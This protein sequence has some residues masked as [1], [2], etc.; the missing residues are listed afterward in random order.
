MRLPGRIYK[1][2]YLL[3]IVIVYAIP[4]IC[5]FYYINN[6]AVNVPFWDQW[7]STVRWVI[8]YYEGNF[9][10]GELTE[11]QNDS[12]PFVTNALTIVISLMTRLNMKVVFFTGYIFYIISLVVIIHFVKKDTSLDRITLTL[13]VPLFYYAFN[14]YYLVA[15]SQNQGCLEYSIL[16]LAALITTY[17]LYISKN[18]YTYFFSSMVM[19][20]VCTFTFAAGLSI[21]FAGLF[22]LGIQDMH[23]KKSK[24]LIWIASTVTIFYV[25][26]VQLGFSTGSS[27]HSMDGYSSFL[28][29]I[30]H[31]PI[32][33]FLCFM[34]ALGAEVIH[35]KDIS[36]YFGLILS[37][38]VIALIYVNRKSLNL[39]QFSKW[40]GL[41]AFGTLTTLELALTRSGSGPYFGYPDTIFFIPADRHSLAIFLPIICIY[42][43]TILYTKDTMTQSTTNC[44]SSTDF[45]IFFREGK[46]LNLFLLGIIFVLLSL[47]AVLH[48]VPGIYMGEIIHNQQVD[49]QHYLETYK[50][51][52]D[53][54]LKNLHPNPTIVRER[55]R[56]LEKY[57]LSVFAEDAID[58]N[59]YP[60]INGVTYSCVDVI[61]NEVVILQT[62]P[63]IIDN[64]E[65]TA[66]GWAVDRYADSPASAVFIT[67]D[68]K[69]DFP[70][71][72]GLDRPD[73]ADVY[74]N[75]NF[76][77]SG[78]KAS[79][80]SSLLENSPHNLTIKIVSRDKRGYYKSSQN[81][82]F[83]VE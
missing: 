75:N 80:A 25:Y 36:L 3:L 49:N 54:N 11:Q 72:Y 59:E 12:R 37:F 41:L 40:Y 14:P 17:L 53:E 8:E 82:E 58:I 76:R 64:G 52:S 22:Q 2:Y 19:G 60:E 26:F 24:M 43:L 71:T 9:N 69:M 78:F 27:P 65:I 62:E 7:D 16:I 56:L 31:Y 77:Y 57:H 55:A 20:L 44:S 46:H 73:V 81:V 67:I 5:G 10:L 79:L 1:N 68:D 33:K 45:Q 39:N 23:D 83:I 51:Q 61:N 30:R 35:Q 15:F 48:L 63:I 66:R 74:K 4:I 28:E 47:G 18:S 34:G 50:I 29:A 6:C 42:I 21:W 13:L 70:S 32:H 38:S